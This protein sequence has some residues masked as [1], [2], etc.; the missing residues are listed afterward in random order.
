MKKVGKA[1]NSRHMGVLSIRP[2]TLGRK[3]L[4]E[5]AGIIIGNLTIQR[6]TEPSYFIEIC[7]RNEIFTPFQPF[8]IFER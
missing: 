6:E 7:R 2:A 8:D 5:K 3:A 1:Y 4:S